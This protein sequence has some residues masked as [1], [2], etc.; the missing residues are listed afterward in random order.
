MQKR[1]TLKDVLGY[2]WRQAKKY[3][4]S[5][6]FSFACY[7]IAGVLANTLV[8]LIYKEIIDVASLGV[9]HPDSAR[10]FFWVWILG[11]A[12][13][14]YNVIFRSADYFWVFFESNTL[15]DLSDYAFKKIHQ[16]SYVFFAD[17]FSGSLVSKMRR[18]IGSFSTIYNNFLWQIAFRSIQAIGALVV[19]LWQIPIIGVAYFF[20]ILLFV[21]FSLYLAK[22][23]IPYD[24]KESSMDSKSTALFADAVTNALTIKLFSS[25]D[26]EYHSFQ[27]VTTRW[28]HARRLAW[29]IQNYQVAIQG[30]LFVI[31][32]IGIMSMATY[33]WSEG[34]LSVGML[35]LVQIYIFGTFDAVWGLGRA[36][37]IIEKALADAKE[38]VEIFEQEPSV[39]DPRDPEVCRIKAGDIEFRDV[40]FVYEK[41]NQKVFE[42][43]S[44]YISPGEKVGLIGHSGAG[45]T[46]ITKILLRFLDITDGQVLID[47][48]NI[49]NI[50]QDDLRSSIS[51][52]P[53][54]PLLFHRTL[55]ENIAYGKPGATD[56]EI[57]AVAKKA[58]AHEF[59]EKLPKGYD[60]LV[61]ERGIKLSGGERQRVAIARAML[62]DAP[63][64]I[65]DEATSSLDS[66]SEKHIQSAL[67]ELMKGRTTIVIAHRLSTIQKMDR[68]LVVEN[69]RIV[70]EG[71]HRDLVSADG[72]YAVFWK[73][74]AGGFIEE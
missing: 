64:L 44:L 53:Q 48:Q 27:K 33:L 40:S 46:T 16:H 73:Q 55:R 52:V 5:G 31:L 47:G 32:E 35:M 54:E 22:K 20:W 37:L 3:P 13:I 74:Q 21:F 69:G 23:K 10:I 34:Q 42:D 24:F 71:T 67:D 39:K 56:R 70:E 11:G 45:K 17:N 59:I 58:H 1:V 8:P 36:L 30:L 66:V 12:I 38:M 43:F 50:T 28:E 4:K 2:Y 72:V 7:M 15:R 51:Y 49:R 29:I 41:G 18:F 19:L 61:G 62:K 26:R 57:I 60:T 65:L 63:I 25:K 9:S 14:S 6:I 68:I